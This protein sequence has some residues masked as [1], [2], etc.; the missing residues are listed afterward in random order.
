VATNENGEVTQTLDYY[1]YGSQRI[2]TGAFDEQRKF[3]GH[4]Y[5]TENDLTYANA[6]YYGQND[7]RWLSQD[8]ASRDN[9][10]QFLTDPQQ[11]NG[12]SYGRN[13]PLILVDRDG[14]KVELATRQLNNFEGFVANFGHAFLVV[15]PDNP[16]TIGSIQGI[17]TSVPFTLSA[18]NNPADN[19]LFKAANAPSDYVAPTGDC[20]TCAF[21]TV[22][23]P[24]GMSSEE[25][26]RRVVASYNATPDV[27][28]RYS[29]VGQVRWTGGANSNNAATTYLNQAGITNSQVNFYQSELSFKNGKIIPGLGQSAL[30]PTYSASAQ[31]TYNAI[32]GFFSK[33]LTQW[34]QSVISL[35]FSLL[36]K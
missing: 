26:D 3:T 33:S 4:E 28:R 15:T 8:P 23:P 36:D 5:D 25:F 1:P 32:A 9:P 22:A 30:A 12:Y 11:F 16:S 24:P 34:Q 6:R 20:G 27:L 18:F 17:D 7:G 19:T 21:V 31:Q 13:N 14:R 29:N 10:A 2:G 35:A